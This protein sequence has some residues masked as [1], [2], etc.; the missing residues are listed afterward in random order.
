MNKA[1]QTERPKEQMQRKK[2]QAHMVMGDEDG[3]ASQ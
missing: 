1:S 3:M 2:T